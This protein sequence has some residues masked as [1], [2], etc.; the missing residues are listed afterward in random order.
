MVF[1]LVTDDI[2]EFFLFDV[3]AADVDGDVF[4]LVG[5]LEELLDGVNGVAIEFF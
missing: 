3:S 4:V 5:I 2:L 1:P